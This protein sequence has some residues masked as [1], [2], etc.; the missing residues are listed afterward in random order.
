MEYDKYMDVWF[1]VF[2]L[3]DN[4]PNSYPVN[5]NFSFS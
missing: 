5:Q 3:P 2:I 1:G 4:W